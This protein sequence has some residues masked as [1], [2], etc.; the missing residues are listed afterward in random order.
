[1]SKR[2][3]SIID[4]SAISDTDRMVI[5]TSKAPKHLVGKK[6]PILGEPLFCKYTDKINLR[7]LEIVREGGTD[8]I[9]SRGKN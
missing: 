4:F 8:M 6:L 9:L 1:M 5:F 3:K 2:V 7:T